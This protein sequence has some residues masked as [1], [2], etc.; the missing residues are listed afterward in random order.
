MPIIIQL[1]PAIGGSSSLTQL[2]T[3]A[4]GTSSQAASTG[5]TVNHRYHPT[6]YKHYAYL[7]NGWSKPLRWN[8]VEN[9][10][11]QVGI[12]SPSQTINTWTP[13]PSTAAGSVG[14][15]VHLV[16]YRYLDSATG[17]VSNPSEERQIAVA[18][19]AKKLTF[20]VS[21]SGA[22]NII[23]STDGKVD[24]I[25]IE[26]T[27]AGGT[28]FFEAARAPNTSSTID[29]DI[30]DA[31]LAVSF[32]GWPNFGHEPPP[33][34]KYL[35]AHRRRLWAFGQVKHSAGTAFFTNGNAVVTGNADKD[36]NTDVFGSA[37]N[38]SDVKWFIKKN[39]DDEEYE[40]SHYDSS[41][42]EITIAENYTG[43][44]TSSTGASVTG[45]G[46]KIGTRANVIWVSNPGFPEGFTSFKFIET[47]Q[48]VF[49]GH[50]TAGVGYNNAMIFYTQHSM[51][52]LG[53]DQDPLVDPFM[54]NVS[55]KH[56]ALSQR[57]VVEVE[58]KIFAMDQ[59]G[60]HVFQGGFPQLIS[61]PV[62]ELFPAMNFLLKENFHASYFP[63]L[64]AIRWFFCNTGDSTNYP[65][66]YLQFDL[67][68]GNWSTGRYNQGISESRLVP[69]IN[70]TTEV[71]YGDE[72][73]HTWVA[74]TG[75]ADGV[76]S[77]FSH[78]TAAAGTTDTVI[79]ATVALPNTNAGISGAFIRWIEGDETRRIL[80][81]NDTSIT[82]ASAFSSTPATGAT[83]WVGMI[84]TKLK[85]KAFTAARVKNKKRSH[86][87]TLQFQPTTRAGKL[88]ARIYEDYS[89]TKKEWRTGGN[90]LDGLTWPATATSDWQVDM[91]FAD[92]VVD[93]PI[94]S[95]YRRCFEVELE[96]DE[97]DVPIEILSIEHDGGEVGDMT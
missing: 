6:E 40:I 95:E 9:V 26:M 78:L 80:S 77:T 89:S 43:T 27:V 36:W 70:G 92:G 71:L 46:Y 59:S 91:S 73:G 82:L 4:I 94:G 81:N 96:I 67:D 17:Y 8:G 11:Y 37:A 65:T 62:E 20:A 85:T 50:L 58:G 86:Y 30:S 60:I 41:S 14:L 52:R 72:N 5:A 10:T 29:V 44:S 42:G 83:F 55:I 56:G 45:E 23:R 2:N 93:I 66:N 75:T 32:L 28:A 35:Y 64:R 19:A 22:A 68:T 24:T 16:R 1:N 31:A 97:P 21:T 49:S 38:T 87:L 7:A 90:D 69:W 54:T 47:P 61:K 76:S 84:P 18:T 12:E 15:G 13:S 57:V 34:T 51:F 63:R 53:W 25:V 3:I 74:D 39:G 79:Q 88:N 48:G 33:V